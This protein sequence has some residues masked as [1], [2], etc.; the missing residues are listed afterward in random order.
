MMWKEIVLLSAVNE[1]PVIKAD[2][3]RY[4]MTFR[5]ILPQPTVIGS[6]PLLTKHLKADSK[7]VHTYAASCIEKVLLIHNPSTQVAMLVFSMFDAERQGEFLFYKSHS[8]L[9]RTRS[10][11]ARSGR[12]VRRIIRGVIEARIYGKR[13]RNER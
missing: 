13:I 5:N 1:I 6:L 8:C 7:V 9:Q 12:T 3:I 2:C 10:F 11:I 4:L